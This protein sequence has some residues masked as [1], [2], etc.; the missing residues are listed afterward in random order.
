MSEYIHCF[1][2]IA[3][4]SE[5]GINYENIYIFEIEKTDI[6]KDFQYFESNL[7][8]IFGIDEISGVYR[9]VIDNEQKIYEE[10]KLSDY[11]ENIMIYKIVDKI[12]NGCN[13]GLRKKKFTFNI[14]NVVD[15]FGNTI[16]IDSI[17]SEIKQKITSQ[18]INNKVDIYT[19]FE[20][21]KHN[22]IYNIYFGF[23]KD[24]FIK[25]SN[26][27]EYTGQQYYYDNENIIC[28]FFHINGRIEGKYYNFRE[29]TEIDY[30]NGKKHGKYMKYDSNENILI[31]CSYSDNKLNGEYKSYNNVIYDN[32]YD[33]DDSVVI[34][35][36][37]VDGKIHGTFKY[38]DNIEKK[39]MITTYNNGIEDGIRY[40]YDYSG[41]LIVE[42][43][44]HD[45]KKN[46]KGYEYKYASYG[47]YVAKEENY[48]NDICEGM[49]KYYNEYGHLLK[50]QDSE[51]T[52]YEN[53]PDSFHPYKYRTVY[54]IT[55]YYSSG[56]KKS[57]CKCK[58]IYD[59]SS[60]ISSHVLS[61]D[62]L[63]KSSQYNNSVGQHR[64]FTQSDTIIEFN[65]SGEITK[66]YKETNNF[67]PKE[68]YDFMD[69]HK[70]RKMIKN[71]NIDSFSY[72]SKIR[73]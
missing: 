48:K 26:K 63:N 46:G 42:F 24:K 54:T 9:Y 3:I 15:V 71:N 55:T 40:I 62:H 65:E 59:A 72:K 53:Y 51:T 4:P 69:E 57:I 1:Y 37:Y 39:Y 13:I 44:I 70:E 2:T 11:N 29:R 60:Q 61:K 31:E 10:S 25:I 18:R 58:T 34:S 50:S 6:T 33:Y 43:E 41:N 32:E 68:F 66:K 67:N 5:D 27:L 56:M 14:I 16:D 21:A 19:D 30:V 52:I 20:H 64:I 47:R 35:C 22:M 17:S 28:D 12:Y 45:G 36:I 7:G 23:N 49:Q 73:M 38:N 8:D